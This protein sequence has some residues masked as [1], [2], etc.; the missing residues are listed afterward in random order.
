[1]RQSSSSAPARHQHVLVLSILCVAGM[2]PT[3][4]HTLASQDAKTTASLDAR[5]VVCVPAALWQEIV[6]MPTQPGLPEHRVRL[7]KLMQ[8]LLRERCGSLPEEA[9]QMERRRPCAREP[10]LSVVMAGRNDGYGGGGFARRLRVSVESLLRSA[11]QAKLALEVVVTE[12][13]PLQEQSDRNDPRPA[14]L[15]EILSE[16]AMLVSCKGA[17][18]E[19]CVPLSVKVVRVER[20]EDGEFREYHAK[21]VGIREAA[22]YILLRCPPLTLPTQADAQ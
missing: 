6:A 20:G 22:G 9:P 15:V 5:P 16:P 4:T 7:H 10:F 18:A 3:R 13:E 1:M 17:Q 12:W 21:N 14:S 11:D 19:D 8:R 2:P